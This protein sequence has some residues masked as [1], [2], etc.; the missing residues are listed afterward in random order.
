MK[1]I[2]DLPH[3]TTADG[4]DIIV[5]V[6]VSANVTSYITKAEFLNDAIDSI[7]LKDL[8]VTTAKL[9]PNAVTAAK[10][11]V[12]EAWIIPTMQNGWVRYDTSWPEAGYY[13]DSLGVVRLRGLVKSGTIPSTI[14]TLPA[15]YRPGFRTMLTTETNGGG[16]RIDVEPDGRVI[17]QGGTN[18]WVT[19][20]PVSFRAEA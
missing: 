1:K 15:G 7:N 5:L 2:T 20:P 9:G 12:Q 10:I 19:L 4:N 11:E 14:F 13:K 16:A 8:S 18:G 17:I 6:D 3:L